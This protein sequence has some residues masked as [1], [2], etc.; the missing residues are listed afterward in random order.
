MTALRLAIDDYLAL[1]RRLGSALHEAA[2]VLHLFAAFAEREG[3]T[4]VTTDLARRWATDVPHRSP[5]SVHTRFQ[6]VRR[7]AEWHH[8]TD[9]LTDIPPIDLLPARYH[10]K[11]PSL[12]QDADIDRLLDAARHLPSPR[13]LRGL[14]LGTGAHVRC[15]GKGRKQRCTPMHRETATL[16]AAWLRER[17]GQ[18]RD[19]VFP[20]A[21]GATL[22]R[23]AVE[24]LVTRHTKTAQRHCAS[25]TRKHVSP[26]VLRHTA[27]ME[28]LA[29]GVDRAVI[30]LWLGHESVETTQ[31]YLHADMR[32]KERALART[33][34]A[35]VT[36]GRYHPTDRLLA[37]LEGL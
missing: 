22:S 7:F 5:V 3:A 37:F 32:I 25:L 14:T 12:Y 16:I 24:R 29:H 18:P 35:G 17:N 4:R 8:V 1:R 34:P 19:P 15:D 20:T 2:R 6:I 33:T 9:P 21:R 31:M 27:A 28:L 13:G 30:A 23:D 36:P 10:R 26:H 11:P